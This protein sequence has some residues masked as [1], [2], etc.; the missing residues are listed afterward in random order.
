MTATVRHL[1]TLEL[2]AGLEEIQRSPK[3]AGVLEMIVRR[4]AVGERELLDEGRLD[5]IEGLVGDN[6]R[7][8]LGDRTPD[9]YLQLTLMNA[10]VT[11]LVAQDKD[12]WPLAGDQLYVDLD[13]SDDTLPPGTRLNIGS[14][15]IEISQQPHTG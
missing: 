14:A 5:P 9:P 3:N 11:G 13:L 12:R 15:I 6:W 4:P 7:G 8:R 10:R 2:E 1:T